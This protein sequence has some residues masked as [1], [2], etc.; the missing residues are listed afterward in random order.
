VP[1]IIWI[2][3]SVMPLSV[4]VVIKSVFIS[5][6]N[7]RLM[8]FKRSAYDKIGGHESV[9]ESVMEDMALGKRVIKS[10][11]KWKLL[12]LKEITSCRMYNDFREAYEGFSKNLFGIFNYHT[13][14]SVF[15]WLF[16]AMTYL[17]PLTVLIMAMC[18]VPISLNAIVISSISVFLTLIT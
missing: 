2:I 11:F 12:N 3:N 15:I 7:S 16:I 1:F 4:R 18:G 6:T 17:L 10:G 5:A 14:I 13:T 8:L 9:K